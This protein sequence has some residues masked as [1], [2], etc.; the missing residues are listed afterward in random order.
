MNLYHR[1]ASKL[2]YLFAPHGSEQDFDD[3]INA[4]LA[5]LAGRFRAQGMTEEEAWRASRRQFGNSTP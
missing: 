4:H 2:R 1:M 3:E 5:M